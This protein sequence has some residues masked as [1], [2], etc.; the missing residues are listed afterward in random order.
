MVVSLA[1]AGR[2]LP[3]EIVERPLAGTAEARR[4]ADGVS[5]LYEHT[6]SAR[7]REHGPQGCLRS[8]LT[9]RSRH[10]SP[11]V[12]RQR[13]MYVRRVYIGSYN[14]SVVYVSSW[15]RLSG[16]QTL[17][18]ATW[19]KRMNIIKHSYQQELTERREGVARTRSSSCLPSGSMACPA[20][21]A[22]IPS[23]SRLIR[24]GLGLPG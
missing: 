4:F 12:T 15:K 6:K 10:C 17:P 22:W 19:T 2:E 21:P 24:L 8:H 9:F 11:C 14:F 7:E 5:G 23:S 20:V 3:D 16:H 18:Q 1:P 13:P